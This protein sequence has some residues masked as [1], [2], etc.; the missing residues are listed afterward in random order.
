MRKIL[1]PK[2]ERHRIRIGAFASDSGDGYNGC[3]SFLTP[4]DSALFVISSTGA[5][6]DHVSVSPI[7]E[8]RTPTWDEM[9]YVKD[10]FFHEDET[11][12]QFHPKKSEYVN[13]NPYVLHLW[14]K[15]GVDLEL[16]PSI[17]TGFRPDQMTP[18][19]ERLVDQTEKNRKKRVRRKTKRGKR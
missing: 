17:L 12:F 5:G 7:D 2:L 6:W 16:P 18:E 11:V 4:G 13:M 19:L 14:K 9:C 1:L 10:L 3:F 15:Q 8:N